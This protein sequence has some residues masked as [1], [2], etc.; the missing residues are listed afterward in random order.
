ML[1]DVKLEPKAGVARPTEAENTT[2]I[3]SARLEWE[4]QAGRLMNG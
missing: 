2:R 4:F 3:Q 1:L